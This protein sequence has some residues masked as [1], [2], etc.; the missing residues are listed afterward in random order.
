LLRICRR[1][2]LFM[3][4][5]GRDLF[6][7]AA[8]PWNALRGL[9]RP[10][11]LHLGGSLASFRL[12][13][14][15]HTRLVRSSSYQY[16]GEQGLEA[17][18]GDALEETRVWQG[19]TSDPQASNPLAQ[20][21]PSGG[22]PEGLVV[23]GDDHFSQQEFDAV[24][25]RWGHHALTRRVQGSGESD[26]PGV[27][28]GSILTLAPDETRT[29]DAF[30]N[31][32]FLVTHAAHVIRDGVYQVR[33]ACHADGAP[34]LLDPAR[35][36]REPGTALLSAVVTDAEDPSR[37]GR[38]LA[39]LNAYAEDELTEEV[40]V[41]ML[42]DGS[43]A[44]HGTLNLPEIGD[45]IILSLDPRS[46]K[47]PLALG[48]VYNGA[49]KT[50]LDSLPTTAGM[51]NSKL[52]GNNAK[53]YLSKAGTCIVHDTTEGSARLIIATPSASVILSEESPASFDI[54]VGG[55]ICQIKGQ[56]DGALSIKAKNITIEAEEEIKI[57]SGTPATIEAGQDLTLK[58]GQNV[59][60]EAAANYEMK[61][62][63]AKE[64][65]STTFEVKGGVNLKLQAVLIEIN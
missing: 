38:V 56:D 23:E 24:A 52:A 17:S 7:H 31:V 9:D 11:E 29:F 59:K 15:A 19:P 3:M 21:V 28:L 25:S 60:V 37:I 42:A 40:W 33:F 20:R 64:E 62:M 1:F 16:F 57:K 35:T 54:Q 55:G 43:G 47:A 4:C 10:I 22:G 50:L 48:S 2:G 58:G 46:F 26:L 65:A 61:S 32:R 14:G 36:E 53:Y 44:D 34:P 39:R 45:E 5:R 51:D 8:D 12:G 18:S 49:A 13:V 27:G 30:E 63:G 6:I 41:R